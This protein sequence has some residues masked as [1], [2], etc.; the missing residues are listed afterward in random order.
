MGL[1]RYTKLL[2]LWVQES[3][4]QAVLPPIFF[5][6]ADLCCFWWKAVKALAITRPTSMTLKKKKKRQRHHHCAVKHQNSSKFILP[7]GW[8][9]ENMLGR[10]LEEEA[11][12]V[13]GERGQISPC[14]AITYVNG[15]NQGLEKNFA[16]ITNSHDLQCSWLKI[17]T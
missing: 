6:E 12:L 10:L 7:N 13:Y 8:L 3:S 4:Q 14:L 5:R 17:K 16:F 9:V 15:T 11:I 1:T 2:L